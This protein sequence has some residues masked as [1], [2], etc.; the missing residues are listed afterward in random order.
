MRKSTL[1]LSAILTAALLFA[2]YTLL[3]A[4]RKAIQ[5]AVPSTATVAAPAENLPEQSAGIAA[6]N[7][8]AEEFTIYDAA[9]LAV[10]V[11]GRSDLYT[12]E[13]T[14]LNGADVYLATFASGDLMYISRDGQVLS[15]SKTGGL[16]I[17]QPTSHR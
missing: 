14:Q 16:S 11:L 15:T 6:N 2:L 8:T 12:T 3:S 13:N 5:A 9:A 1:I 17:Y 10:K 4:Y 7:L